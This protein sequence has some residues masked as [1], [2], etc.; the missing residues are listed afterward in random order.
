MQT[1]S[2][3]GAAAIASFGWA[4]GKLLHFETARYIPLWFSA[5]LFV[6]N[7]DRIRSDPAD[8]VNIPRRHRESIRLRGVATGVVIG[9]G[10]A[11]VLIPLLTQ[12]W[13]TLGLA[14][15]GSA[16]CLN[17]SVPLLGSRLKDIPLLKTFFAPTLVSAAFFGLPLLHH[18]LT[19]ASSFP[20]Y[21]AAW[22]WM[23][24]LFN[25]ILCDLRD[26]KGDK[27]ERTLSVP[28]VLGARRTFWVLCSI[29]VLLCVM[30]VAAARG[31][32]MD[33]ERDCAF[34]SFASLAYLS[35]LA[36]AARKTRSEA[37][38]EWC[39]EGMIFLPAVLTLVSEIRL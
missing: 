21:V 16:V 17:Y 34:I 36:I 3:Y 4:L 10:C 23:F 11:L 5:A 31:T 32:P 18:R 15:C 29:L 39:V 20:R 7:V 35:I 38:Y 28:V 26:I 8:S 24:L 19:L 6:Y 30:S 1:L 9:S 37:F 14:V 2:V 25:M 12:D 27:R 13:M 22:T 33:R